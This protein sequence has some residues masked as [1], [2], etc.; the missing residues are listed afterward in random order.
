MNMYLNKNTILQEGK[1]KIVRHISSGGFGNTYEGFDFLLNKRVAI[2]EFY[3][4]DFCSRD[5]CTQRVYVNSIE[6]KPLIEHLKKKFVEPKIRN[7][8]PIHD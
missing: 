3:I 1:Y 2:K 8:H 4:N 5:S 7:Y 6:N